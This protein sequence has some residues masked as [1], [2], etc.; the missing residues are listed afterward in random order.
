MNVNDINI[1]DVNE[2]YIVVEKPHSLPTVPLSYHD[3]KETL[4]S[5]IAQKYPEV[6]GTTYEGFTLHRL[7]TDT[8]GLVVIARNENWYNYL[9]E[10]QKLGRFI[11]HYSALTTSKN[12]SKGYPSFPFTI[13]TERIV[14]ITSSFRAY[15]VGRKEVRPVSQ[16]SST[17]A[18]KKGSSSIY[19]TSVITKKVSEEHTLC[20]ISL[21]KGFRHQVRS[22][23]AWASMPIIGDPIYGGKGHSLL[24]L[25]S[26]KVGFYDGI[27]SK[28]V[29]Y[30]LY[31]E[32]SNPFEQLEYKGRTR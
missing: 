28:R 27:T 18:Q 19:T 2:N 3:D 24:H 9:L 10:Q 8:R 6:L 17:F 20:T 12:L 1:L 32:D 14:D 5:L 30:R 7:D 11:K 16:G 22:H 29:E 21:D 23:L 4:L 15:G 31:D 25:I 26:Y 13:S